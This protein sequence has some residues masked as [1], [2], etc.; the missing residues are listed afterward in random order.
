MTISSI[1]PANE[2]ISILNN[3]YYRLKK[4]GGFITNSGRNYDKKKNSVYVVGAGSCFPQKIEGITV[5]L[6]KF[7]GNEILRF[8][9]GIFVG[10]PL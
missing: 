3:S 7:D 8:G 4:R 2:D 9:R 5:V 10:L 1:I 6:D